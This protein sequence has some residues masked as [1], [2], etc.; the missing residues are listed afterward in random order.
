[1]LDRGA[2]GSRIGPLAPEQTTNGSRP[3]CFNIGPTMNHPELIAVPILMLADYALTILGAKKSTAV[4]RNHFTMP[5]YEL[6]PVW[7]KSVDQVRWFNFR[8]LS[9][10]T[11]VTLLLISVDQ[12]Q[13]LP[14]DTFALALGMLFGA[15]GSICGR[16][17]TNLLLF[18]YL[19][20]HPHEISGQVQLSLK[21]TL[22]ISQF[23]YIGLLPLF[24]IVVVLDPNPYTTGVLLGVLVLVFAHFVWGFRANRSEPQPKQPTQNAVVDAEA[25]PNS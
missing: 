21:L 23:T 24:A 18:N 9:L 15:F 17:L 10:V 4:Y 14:Y 16:H 12:T 5:S 22:K 2:G 7:R 11:L 8:H 19:N 6:N 20:R 1:M 3:N 25:H 13:M